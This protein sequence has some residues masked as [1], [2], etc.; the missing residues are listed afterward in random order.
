[1]ADPSEGLSHLLTPKELKF[2]EAAKKKGGAFTFTELLEKDKNKKAL[3]SMLKKAVQMK[4]LTK[5]VDGTYLV[6]NEPVQFE[7][8]A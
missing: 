3:S 5:S 6:V 7:T 1:M 8:A 2:W 4:A